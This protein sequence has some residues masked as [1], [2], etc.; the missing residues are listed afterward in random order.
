MLRLSK[1]TDYG[2]VV[3]AHMARTPEAVHTAADVASATHVAA[4][5]VS[6]LL[7]LL[8]RGG[9][10]VSQRGANGGYSLAREPEAISAV[11]VID[12]IEGPV[13]LTA[14]SQEEGLCDI[15]THCHIGSAWQRI[16]GAIR[17]ALKDVSLSELADPDHLT[18]PAVNIGKHRHSRQEPG[19]R[20]AIPIKVES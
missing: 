16:N 20:I 3:L 5:T 7:K 2:T 8:T 4:P 10:L 19:K 9:L 11:D 18:P 13:G 15:E 6:K 17:A 1:L 14:C 12:A